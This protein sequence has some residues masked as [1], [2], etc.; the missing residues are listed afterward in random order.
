MTESPTAQ[1]ATLWVVLVFFLGLG[2]GS[3]AGFVY[4]HHKFPVTNAASAPAS[5]PISDAQRRALKVQELSNMANLTIEQTHQ[6]EG[7][8]A[9]LQSRI[10]AI[11]KTTD[12]QVD[13]V[14]KAGHERIRAILTPE[15]LPKYEE[16][17]QK[18]DED[19]KRAGQ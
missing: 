19:R 5:W 18:L 6:V 8:V 10:K 12:P 1:K 3:M 4:A 11:R 9:D 13:E 7:I 16:F 17:V 15:Q 14:R 2:L